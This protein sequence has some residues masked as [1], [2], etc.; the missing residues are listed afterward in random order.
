MQRFILACA[1][2]AIGGVLTVTAFFM[3]NS[4]DRDTVNAALARN[5]IV[6]GYSL[7]VQMEQQLILTRSIEGLFASSEYVSRDEFNRFGDAL[8]NRI[9]NVVGVGW[10]PRVAQAEREVYEQELGKIG[11]EHNVFWEKNVAGESVK[12]AAREEYFP[13]YYA[14]PFA[15]AEK[16]F[17]YDFAS[18][19]PAAEAM[20]LARDT[21]E[22]A[23]AAEIRPAIGGGQ[24]NR[25]LSFI[26]YYGNGI[27]PATVDERRAALQGFV[28]GS[29]Q[30][31]KIMADSLSASDGKGIRF[32]LYD[33]TEPGRRILLYADNMDGK[34]PVSA[35]GLP[36]SGG[37]HVVSFEIGNRKWN[38]VAEATP[39]FVA[40]WSSWQPKVVLLTGALFTLLLVAFV[41]KITTSSLR[42]RLLAEKETEARQLAESALAEQ[43]RAEVALRE[44]E[45]K[46]RMLFDQSYDFV[47][48]LSP[49]G[50]LLDVNG[51]ALEFAGSSKESV[52]NRP[53]WETVWWSHS[54]E[55]QQQLRAAIAQ[56]ASGQTVKFETTHPAADGNLHTFDISLCPI[57]DDQGRVALLVPE[58]RDISVRKLM[59]QKLLA[60]ENELRMLIDQSPIGLTLCTLDGGILLANPV[61]ARITGYSIEEIKQLNTRDI[62]PEKYNVD[63]Q[64]K[65][66]QLEGKGRFGPYEK[67]YRHKDGHLVPVRV[68]GILVE[69]QGEKCIWSSVEDI[70]A[71]KAA[72]EQ[73]YQLAEQLRQ[74]QKMEA[75]GTLA[76]GIAH[77]FNNILS[78]VLGYTELSLRNPSCE[79]KVKKNLEYVLMAAERGRDLVRQILLYSRKEEDNRKQLAIDQ[80]IQGT[81]NLLRKTIPS[82]IPIR[83][84]LS[85]VGWVLGD[86]TQIQ[87]VVMNLCTNAS[88]ALPAQ[89]G[90]ILVGLQQLLI[91]QSASEWPP[92]LTQ[93][94]YAMLTVADNGVGIPPQVLTHIFDPFFTTKAQGKGTGL[95]LSVVHGIVKRHGGAITVESEVGKGT[96][97]KV[98]FP[99]IEAADAYPAAEPALEVRGGT[100]HILWVDD[101]PM[102]KELGLEML[103]TLGYRVTAT[104]SANEAL[105]LFQKKPD[106]F[107]LLISDQTMPEMPGADLMARVLAIRPGFPVILCTGHSEVLNQQNALSLG[108]RSLLMKPLECD[109]LAKTI[110][111][112]LD[113]DEP[114]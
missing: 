77:D 42:A 83:L 102:L 2:I 89:G 74:S 97:F 108:A 98:F 40:S 114:T 48:L 4:W 31:D 45:Q 88:H 107:D 104:V 64:Q 38:L 103:E 41:D 86:E 73:A 22:L 27:S 25:I 13:L 26:P 33:G 72:E 111:T 58:G 49:D 82:T 3:A 28:V 94:N 8:I 106:D 110:R 23:L 44:S 69:R 79:P 71:L 62:T 91:D 14:T 36:L 59:E 11:A 51:T 105:E 113:K 12:A 30:I 56:A 19:S 6:C 55:T 100:E 7:K 39:E 52:L 35:T 17:G 61:Y 109:L 15:A 21:G 93:G 65:I 46:F 5:N 47:G 29:H 60:S 37:Q 53:F 112:I 68:N 80:I 81:V 1:V 87:Q 20:A 75:I 66:A 9:D 96:I 16:V 50:T 95:G 78:A 57:F 92:T 18:Q 90:E 76:G 101:E 43:R 10:L 85:P 24:E 84:S 34:A 63:E 32:F 54:P 99:L 70:S 67:E